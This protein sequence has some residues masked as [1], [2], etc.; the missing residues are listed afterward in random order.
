MR[1]V[2]EHELSDR[3]SRSAFRWSPIRIMLM[4]S[5]SCAGYWVRRHCGFDPDHHFR[6]CPFARARNVQRTH[7]DVS[8]SPGLSLDFFLNFFS[9]YGLGSAVA[10]VIAGVLSEHGAWRW[11]FCSSLLRMPCLAFYNIPSSDMNIPICA[12]TAIIL[13][14]FLDVKTPNLSFKEKM[15]KLDWV[16][17][18]I[19]TDHM[20][21]S[22]LPVIKRQYFDYCEH[23][24]CRP[25]PNLGR[26]RV[27][28]DLCCSPGSTRHWNGRPGRLFDV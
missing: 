22:D 1:R 24:L 17:V 19:P 21:D 15:A 26:S 12:V 9:A 4:S 28:V 11:F 23:D 18:V 25:W 5:D 27:C 2:H 10:P 16:Y 8:A 3:G 6:P 7:C 20:I 14:V 13:V